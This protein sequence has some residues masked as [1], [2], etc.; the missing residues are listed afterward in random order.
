MRLESITMRSGRKSRLRDASTF[1]TGGTN[2]LA[3][4]GLNTT[5]GSSDF[6]IDAE[7][8][9]RS[10]SGGSEPSPGERN[11]SYSTSAPPQIRQGEA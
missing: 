4:H 11:R 3:I 2:V 1:L 5:L 9:D 8:V 7:L 10:T 6:S